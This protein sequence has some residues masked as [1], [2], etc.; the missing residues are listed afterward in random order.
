VFGTAASLPSHVEAKWLFIKE[1]RY[2]R[3]AL[4]ESIYV[5]HPNFFRY[6]PALG[7]LI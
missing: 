6:L 3:E 5:F 7:Q 4:M 1:M 2:S